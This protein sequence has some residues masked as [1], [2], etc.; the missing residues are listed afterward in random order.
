[1]T[2]LRLYLVLAWTLLVTFTAYVIGR[3]GLAGLVR[4]VLR[5]P[6]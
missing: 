4:R 6:A 3:E 1:M 5:R 2:A